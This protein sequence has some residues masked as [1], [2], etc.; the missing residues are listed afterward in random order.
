M[1][2][3][4]SL[5]KSVEYSQRVE[6]C[7]ALLLDALGTMPLPGAFSLNHC[8][9]QRSKRL[10]L[11]PC[12]CMSM[13]RPSADHILPPNCAVK[14]MEASQFFHLKLLVRPKVH[15]ACGLPQ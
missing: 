7:S 8:S 11:V 2:I 3:F 6:N 1:V 14:R 5:R 10:M 12:D 13:A 15:D 9:V 4:F